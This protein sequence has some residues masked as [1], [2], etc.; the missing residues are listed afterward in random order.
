MGESG[1][2]E[3]IE[4]R[5]VGAVGL[6]LLG[7]GRALEAL[8][9]LRM[10]RLLGRRLPDVRIHDTEQA[11]KLAH[12]V[13]ARAFTVG[14]H[15][16]APPGSLRP[17]TGAGAGLLA[18]EL[19]HVLQQTQPRQHAAPVDSPDSTRVSHIEGHPRRTRTVQPPEGDQR[20][21]GWTA[22]LAAGEGAADS[23]AGEQEAQAMEAAVRTASAGQERSETSR[24]PDPE[25]L[26]NKVYQLMQEEL[27]LCRERVA[28][29]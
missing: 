16:F 8:S 21:D 14:P 23:P 9:R 25:E 10:E 29:R 11:A 28:L 26:A 7:Q 19:T 12:Q 18:H 2:S 4:E 6:G 17:D 13:G 15:I 27:W 24:A 5:L 1:V 22:Q 20:V 3:K